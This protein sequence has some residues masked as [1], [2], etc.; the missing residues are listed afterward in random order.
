MEL[1]ALRAFVAVVRTGSF[2]LA[3]DQLCVTQPTISKLVHQLEHE[4]DLTL[5]QRHS[6]KMVVTD[7]GNIVLG[8]AEK[9]LVDADNIGSALDDLK[10][11]KRGTLRIG[12]PPLGPSLFVPMITAYKLLYPNIELKLFEE[13]SKAIEKALLNRDLDFGGLLAPVNTHVFNQRSMIQDQL[14]L[15]SPAQSYW[16]NRAEVRLIELIDEP[17]ILFSDTYTLNHHILDACQQQGFTPEVAGRSG[18][19][20]FILELVS[21]GVGVALLPSSA[22]AQFD[23]RNFA[24]STLIEPIIPW[25]I[26]LVWLKNTHESTAQKRW[27]SLL[28]D[29]EQIGL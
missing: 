15:V 6:K 21:S 28:N 3:A 24:V 14:A 4:F 8:Y 1:W 25:C 7:A 17:F 27:L 18:Q 22:L 12:I 19:I 11:L 20:S 2:T 10:G 29:I 13:G 16:N 23:M 9:M 5:L 26:D